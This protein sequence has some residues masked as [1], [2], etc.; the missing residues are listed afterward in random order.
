MCASRRD[1]TK[2]HGEMKVKAAYGW[3]RQDPLPLAGV[4]RTAGPSRSPMTTRRSK[5]AHAGTRKMV[6]YA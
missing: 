2:P 4:G 1:S 3:P 5:S 6:N